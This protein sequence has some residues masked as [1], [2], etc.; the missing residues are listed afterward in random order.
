MLKYG[1][2]LNILLVELDGCVFFMLFGCQDLDDLVN[3]D[4]GQ[5][6]Y[7]MQYDDVVISFDVDLESFLVFYLIQD[8]EGMV[9]QKKVCNQDV[10]WFW[11]CDVQG[12]L[13]LG[14]IIKNQEIVV[15]VEWIVVFVGK[16]LGVFVDGQNQV[17][18]II[19][20][21]GVV[22][23]EIMEEQDLNLFQGVVWGVMDLVG[24]FIGLDIWDGQ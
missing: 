1:I 20:W 19:D 5:V 21:G 13:V 4:V 16:V 7:F 10:F 22:I 14:V 18:F 2:Y 15:F 9:V 6:F 24:L 17:W 8:V 3:F 11:M 12:C 23:Y